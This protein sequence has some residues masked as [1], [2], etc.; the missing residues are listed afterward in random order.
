MGGS[1]GF[2]RTAC[3]TCHPVSDHPR[4][5][6]SVVVVTLREAERMRKLLPALL[7]QLDEGD[8]LIISDNGSTDGTLDVVAQMAPAA[9]VVRNGAN[10]GFAAACNRGAEVARGDL[11]VLLNPD[12]IPRPGCAEALRRPATDARGWTA[13][14]ALLTE[15]DGARVNSSGGVTHYTGIAWAGQM[16]E[17]ISV[18]P[19][20]AREVGFVSGG[21]MV[22]PLEVW[23]REGGF[24]EEFFAYHEDTDLSLRLLLHGGRL[25][26][27]PAA[28]VE[29]EYEFSRTPAK[30]RLLERNRWFTLIRTYPARLLVVL[31]PA[32]LATELGV[33]ALA[34]VS[35][36][37][38]QKLAANAEVVRALP[39]LL[40]QRREIQAG[41]QV[42]ARE[43]ASHLTAELDSQYLGRAAR[44]PGLNWLL[45]A[46]WRC[47]L[48]LLRS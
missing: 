12:T 15:G 16:S 20:S 32:L 22:M 36:W 2:E 10:L 26:I 40:R 46:Y 14:Q 7:P 45:R 3:I 5:S 35:G 9:L 25:G 30:W 27:E 44:L 29:H 6:L 31:G 4:P 34:L 19:Q 17:P 1:C 39:R 28:V 24:D 37:G 18:A 23:R 43:F 42:G 8:E 11:L 47:A 13:W 38:G 48:A 33:L 21:C 41:A